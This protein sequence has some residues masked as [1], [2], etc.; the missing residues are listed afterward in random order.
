MAVKP[1]PDKHSTVIPHLVVSDVVRLIEF[2]QRAFDAKEFH[3]S[4][5]PGGTVMHAHVHIGESSVMMGQAPPNH[6]LMPAVLYV[7]VTDVDAVYRRAL[8][9]GA[10]SIAEPANQFYGDRVGAVKDPSGNQWWIATHVED[11]SDEEIVRRATAA[12]GGK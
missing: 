11:V 1:I 7:Y 4:T 12:R 9:A 2:L 6:P 3:R 5:F 10:T 8:A